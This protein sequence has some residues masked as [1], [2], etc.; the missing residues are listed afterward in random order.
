VYAHV[1]VCA[2]VSRRVG[3]SGRVCVCLGARVWVLACVRLDVRMSICMC[4]GVCAMC[5]SACVCLGVCVC[6]LLTGT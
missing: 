1:R 5:V 6:Q 2:C 4:I 3:V